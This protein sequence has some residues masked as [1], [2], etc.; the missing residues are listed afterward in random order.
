MNIQFELYKIF[1]HAAKCQNFSQAA[2]ELFITQSAVSQSIKNLEAQ[3]GSPLF[4]R[5]GRTMKLTWE[6]QLLYQHVEKA[7]HLIKSAESKFQEIHS[8]E[9]GQIRIGA[10]DTTCK[11]FLMPYLERFS[12]GHPGIKIRVINRTSPQ[13]LSL[14]K[15]GSLDLAIVTLPVSDLDIQVQRFLTVE[16]VFVASPKFASLKGNV[17][18]LDILAQYPIL[19]LEG[20]SATRR[21]IDRYLRKHGIEITPEIELESN[22]LLVDFARIG[23]GIACVLKES[24]LEEIKNGH[25]FEIRLKEG[26]PL[27]E[28]G[29]CTMRNI[30]PSKA[31]LKFIQMLKEDL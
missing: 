21:N 28:L 12:Q 25:L 27:R 14:L 10:S 6:G 3:L 16:D 31:A 2:R 30:S 15:T 11:Y 19:L 29:I 7:Y 20:K 1:Y 24:A 9:M 22:D 8:L 13:L 18:S 17:I 4:Y 26:L 5:Q 23:L